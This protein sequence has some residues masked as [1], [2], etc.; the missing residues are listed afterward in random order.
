[1][2]PHDATIRRN[3]DRAIRIVYLAK[4]NAGPDPERVCRE[5]QRL[6]DE[7]E[8]RDRRSGWWQSALISTSAWLVAAALGYGLVVLLLYGLVG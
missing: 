4:Q 7:M 2:S 5:M 8:Q 1:M 6:V 3:Q